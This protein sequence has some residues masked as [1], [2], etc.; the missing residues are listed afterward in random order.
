M[1]PPIAV[2]STDEKWHAMHVAAARLIPAHSVSQW[3]QLLSREK[4]RGRVDNYLNLRG[5][6]DKLKDLLAGVF[7]SLEALEAYFQEI[8]GLT[9][10]TTS[11]N[12]AMC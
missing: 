9:R 1:V 6:D 4:V 11:N 3:V 12:E 5:Q 2:V 10:S 8:F 7:K